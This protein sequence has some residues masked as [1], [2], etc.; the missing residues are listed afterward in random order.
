MLCVLR[1]WRSGGDHP[2]DPRDL[3][4]GHQAEDWEQESDQ[5]DVLRAQDPG[6]ADGRVS[7]PP[8][9]R[10]TQENGMRGM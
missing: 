3:A 1:P 5:G 7:W 10:P 9:A 6:V 8:D 2:G 4:P